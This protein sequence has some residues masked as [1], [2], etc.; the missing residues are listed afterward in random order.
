MR[1][2]MDAELLEAAEACG[3]RHH[4]DA[5]VLLARL[6][7]P[8]LDAAAAPGLSL[9]RRDRLL[10]ELRAA[11][12]GQRIDLAAPCPACGELLAVGVTAE[13]L[14]IDG[15]LADDAGRDRPEV[16]LPGGKRVRLRPL[17]SL[18][19]AAVAH[20]QDPAEARRM[21]ARRCLEAFPPPGEPDLP[22]P[23]ELVDTIA[24][25]LAELDPQ[26][27]VFVSL[28]CPACGHQWQAPIDIGL[29]LAHDIEAAARRLLDD[30]HDLA[31]AYHWT[32]AEILALP[33]A[34]RRRYL[35]RVRS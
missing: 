27:D 28:D 17:D 11:T 33:R 10:L 1:A 26:S 13:A 25:R 32:E 7:D 21:L 14:R 15:G 9:G 8:G 30:I 5:A 29:V 34:R 2:L 6:A 3:G 31:G 35:E 4:I 12:F 23:A 19:L 22:L 20:L 18:D 24:G 16:V